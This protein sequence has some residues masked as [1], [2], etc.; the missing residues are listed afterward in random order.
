[1]T[2]MYVQ[3]NKHRYLVTVAYLRGAYTAQLGK[4]P[5]NPFKPGPKLAQYDYGYINEKA[6]QHDAV[7]LPFELLYAALYDYT[8]FKP[9]A[10]TWEIWNDTCR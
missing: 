8:D 3:T 9:H 5:Q 1:M 4:P 7:D 6:G 2:D 10:R